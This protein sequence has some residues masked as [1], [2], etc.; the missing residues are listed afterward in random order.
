MS[1]DMSVFID[2]DSGSYIESLIKCLCHLKE[3]DPFISKIRTV[4]DA[5]LDLSL[6]M[7]HKAKSDLLKSNQTN[8]RPVK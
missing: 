6:L 3:G 1:D 5:E 8:L 7:A 2:Q 4:I